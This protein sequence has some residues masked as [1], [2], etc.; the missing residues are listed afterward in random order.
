L[1]SLVLGI[2]FLIVLG[3]AIYEYNRAR[4]RQRLQTAI[5]EEK[6]RGF[7][8]IILAT[9]EERKRISKDLHDGIGQQL[10]AL[11][12]ALI[13]ISQ[14]FTGEEKIEV[15]KITTSFS[16]AAEEVRAISHQMMPKALLERGLVEAVEDLLQETFAFSQIQY[17]F[18]HSNMERRFDE[19]VEISIYRITQELVNNVV[20]H[21]GATQVSVQLIHV[22]QRLMLLVE[23]NGKGIPTENTSGHGLLNIKS[24]LDMVN[25]NVNLESGVIE[26]TTATITIP[27]SEV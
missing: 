18:E 6:E 17:E 22:G 12:L 3:L 21:S 14:K 4:Q 1:L 27:V 20:K 2:G 16:K 13:H 8:S 7:R 23:D 9:E 25:G 15:E 26:G 19:K 11:R 24:R 10:T 5:L